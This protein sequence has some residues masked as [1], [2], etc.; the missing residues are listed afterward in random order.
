MLDILN[1]ISSKKKKTPS[2]WISFNAPCCDDRRGRGG[3]KISDQGWSYHCFNCTTT[4]SFTLGRPVSLRARKF[5]KILN[6]PEADIDQLTLESL[7][8]RSI[9]GILDDRTRITNSLAG[10]IFTEQDD[11]PAGS[12]I[13]TPEMATHWNYLRQRCVPEDFPAMTAIRN[14]GVH[15]VRPH[16]TIPFTFD[17]KVVGWSA[18]FLDNRTPKYIHHTQPGYVF[19]TDLQK[20]EW[21]YA[22]V[23]EGVF[24]A[25]AINGLAVLHQEINDK[26][27]KVIRNLGREVIVVPDQD[28]SGM[29]LVDQAV[30]LGWSVSMPDWQD[31]KDVNDAVTKYGKLATLVS[32]IQARETS[33]VKIELRKR[34][35][36][37]R[38]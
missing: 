38:F 17:G 6:V 16:V 26:Q 22:I 15:W 2:G 18:R 31:C 37:K 4:A 19:G 21:K 30:E 1:Y 8:H 36:A 33:R 23:V 32:I 12:E 25:L 13:I 9:H 34:Q 35:L 29:T 14:D 3:L 7:R 27:I 20:P 11:F 24:D 5:L 28:A 10:I